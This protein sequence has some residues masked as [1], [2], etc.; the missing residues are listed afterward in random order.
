MI[1]FDRHLKD[2]LKG[3]EI[4]NHTPWEPPFP[5]KVMTLSTGGVNIQYLLT[6]YSIPTS[7]ISL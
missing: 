2:I 4:G 1:Y 6:H 5:S 7:K 3:M